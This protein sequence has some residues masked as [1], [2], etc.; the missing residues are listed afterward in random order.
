M[1]VHY[2]LLPDRSTS[3]VYQHL[4]LPLLVNWSNLFKGSNFPLFLCSSVYFP[5]SKKEM[6]SSLFRDHTK[7]VVH[8]T[9]QDQTM[10]TFSCLWM[11]F[12]GGL[13]DPWI[14]NNNN[15][16]YIQGDQNTMLLSLSLSTL[17]WLF[18]L[19]LRG[20]CK[21]NKW[22]ETTLVSPKLKHCLF[23]QQKLVA[24]IYSSRKHSVVIASLSVGI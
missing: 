15:F 24:F 18:V 9:D 23:I 3:V 1:F 12:V 13:I 19:I 7:Y 8:A 21:C 20:R 6:N 10:R 16:F 17:S 14:G 4:F 5:L 2:M 11:L 22:L